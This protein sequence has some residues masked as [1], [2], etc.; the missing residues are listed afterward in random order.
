MTLRPWLLRPLSS[1]LSEMEEPIWMPGCLPGAKTPTQPGDV[2][3]R[4]FH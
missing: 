2:T 1:M 4:N 3:A